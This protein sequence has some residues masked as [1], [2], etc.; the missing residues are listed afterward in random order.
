MV[1]S[2][3][4]NPTDTLRKQLQMSKSRKELQQVMG[5]L[6]YHRKH[7][8]GFSVI[9]HPLYSLLW[10]GSRGNGTQKHEEAVKTLIQ[11]LKTYWSLGSEHPHNLIIAKWGSAEHS[12]YCNLFQTG[13][14]RPKRPLLFSLTAFKET[15]QKYSEWENGILSLV[16][17][18]KQVD[19]LKGNLSGKVLQR[20]LLF[21]LS[22]NDTRNDTSTPP[23]EIGLTIGGSLT[24]FAGVIIAT[25]NQVQFHIDK[26]DPQVEDSHFFY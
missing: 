17:A 4:S 13:P 25:M 20:F 8:P 2:E 9:A 10:K 18:V 15:E 24:L 6:G 5:T 14:D 11:D 3:Y 22:R 16:W 1:C 21:S 12:T 23:L 19:P 26:F 7:I